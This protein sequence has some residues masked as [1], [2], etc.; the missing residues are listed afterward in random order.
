MGINKCQNY[1]IWFSLSICILFIFS[2]FFSLGTLAQDEKMLFIVIHDSETNLPIEEDI[3]LEGKKYDIAIGCIGEYGYEYNVTV[4]VPSDNP[5]LTSK[6]LPWITV[7]IPDFEE[8]PEFVITVMKD[9]YLSAEQ[10]IRI[11]KGELYITTDRGT[12]QEKK[13]FS[14]TVW[15]QNN[16]KMEEAT[17][18]LDISGIEEDSDE[19]N[20]NGI[21]YLTAPEVQDD[22]EININVFKGGYLPGTA[23]IR[24]ENEVGNILIGGSTPIIAALIVLIFSMV[25]VRV[26]KDMPKPTV[27]IKT[28]IHKKNTENNKENFTKKLT[29]KKEPLNIKPEEKLPKKEKGPWVEEIRINRSDKKKNSKYLLEDT[30]KIISKHKNDE[31]EWFKGMENVKFKIDKLT[32]ES[33]EENEDKWFE[34][35]Y[36]IKSKVNKKVKK[37]SKRKSK[38]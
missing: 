26:K 12:V 22:V 30:E 21:A 6:E 4:N 27:E 10:E 31:N 16:N 17:V 38:S 2:I 7:E 33:D 28:N 14:V 36:D 13:S 9:G 19:T 18:Y 29:L 24:V 34:G 1:K 20:S 8:Y 32:G 35:V 37:N 5:Y 25:F 3:F 15:D 11:L 23:T